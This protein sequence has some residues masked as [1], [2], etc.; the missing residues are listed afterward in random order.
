VQTFSTPAISEA[1]KA[2]ALAVVLTLVVGFMPLVGVILMPALPLPLAFVTL[3]RGVVVGL[4]GAA[5]TGVLCAV[6]GLSTGLLGLLM[7]GLVG[8]LIGW[9]FRK[10]WGFSRSLL[11]AGVGAAGA[12]VVYT[13]VV[14]LLTGMGLDEIARTRD[15]SLAAASELYVKMGMDEAV[16]E[17]T[18]EQVRATLDVLPYLAPSILVV[19]GVFLAAVVLGLAAV[20]FPHVGETRVKRLSFMELR[21][22]WS[23]AYG[24]IAGL[25]LM[26]ISSSLGERQDEARLVAWNLLIITQALFF[27]QGLAVAQWFVVS[28]RMSVGGRVAVYGAAIVGQLLIQLTSWAGLLDTWLDYRKRFAPAPP[29]GDGISPAGR[30]PGD[31]EE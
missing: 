19:S 30:G 16:V 18:V 21:L 4:S 26:L 20:I 8:V 2:I 12:L 25:A 13:A 22:H 3:R 24:F 6:T 29:A 23:L 1:G 31:R 10:G 9:I 28:R 7:A 27:L 5:G 15:E 11:M 17:Q 14:F